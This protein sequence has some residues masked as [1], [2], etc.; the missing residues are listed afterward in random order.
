MLAEEI[1]R[2]KESKTIAD[3]IQTS[4]ASADRQGHASPQADTAENTETPAA[5]EEASGTLDVDY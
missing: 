3:D 4:L 2:R 1:R 5:S